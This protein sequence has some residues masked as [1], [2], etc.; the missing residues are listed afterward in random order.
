MPLSPGTR[1]GPYEV[2]SALGAGGMGEV[3][4]AV[5]TRLNRTVAIK[6][7]PGHLSRDPERRQRF[8]REARVISSLTHPNICTLYDVGQEGGVDFLVMEHL[9][10]E[11]LAD[12]LARERLGMDQVLKVGTDIVAAL[13]RAHRSGVIHRDLKPGNV[14]LTKTGAKLLDFGLA[15]IAEDPGDAAMT[16]LTGVRTAAQGEKPLTEKGTILG[17]FQYMAPE[18]LE[19]KE[20]DARTDLF[21]LGAVLYEMATGR[22]A[23]EGKSQASLIGAIMHAEPP[24]ISSLEPMN[25]PALDRLIKACLAKD[26]EE[27]I[28]TAHDVLLQ[29]RWI[30]EGGSQAGVPAPVAHRRRT[31]ERTAWSAAAVLAVACAAL[32]ATLFLRPA[33]P[34]STIRFRIAAPPGATSI[35]GPKI[36][37][38]GKSLAFSAVDSTGRAMLWLQPLSSLT[39]APVAG[40]EGALRPWWSADGRYLGY[41]AQGKL[42][43]VAVSGGPP[44]TICDAGG[45]ADG[46]WGAGDTIL[47]DG[48]PSDPIRRVPAGGG[49]AAAA[50]TSD[51]S[52]V[53]WP[54]FLPDGRH[55][56]YLVMGKDSRL[57]VGSLDGKPGVPLGITR[58]SRAEYSPAGYLLFV[59]DRSLLAQPFDAAKRQLRGEPVPIAE[60]VWSASNGAAQ[61]SVAAGG[62]LLYRSGGFYKAEALWL[63]R[64]GQE[65]E[66]VAAASSYANP[67]IAPDGK[68]VVLR[69]ADQESGSRDLWTIDPARGTKTRLTF[70]VPVIT[71]CVWSPDGKT[72]YYSAQDQGKA[73]NIFR[74]AASG[75]GASE[76]VSTSAEEQHIAD[77]SRDGKYLALMT[78]SRTNSFDVAVLSLDDGKLTPVVAT[79]ATEVLPRF[80]PDGRWI[81]YVSDESGRSEVYV[82]SFRGP[83]GKWQVSNQGGDE[84][85]WRADGKEIYY[86]GADKRLTAV[87][88]SAGDTFAAGVPKPLFSVNLSEGGWWQY[89]PSADGTRFLVLRPESAEAVAPITIVLNWAAELRGS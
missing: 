5:D 79:P 68:R 42:R 21:A 3:Y 53:G 11:S 1:L 7:L 13:D 4:R 16:A 66:R 55:F 40:T 62:T 82:Q 34:S 54:S 2:V 22:R 17:T 31:R 75:A 48:G 14:M 24:S 70:N 12:R 81:A 29:L 89:Q 43:K 45:G 35:D 63:N 78:T 51:S 60:D 26:P 36:S 87:E 8:E 38:D 25:P 18:Q 19:G 72:I 6:I 73:V 69:D 23:F 80:S 33:P 46:T 61:F 58:A 10:G 76:R 85:T 52:T 88:I 9:E 15:K 47:F 86:V 77:V 57:M 50:V 28:Q 39:A 37:P 27:R 67:S 71:S 49:V 32:S 56:L 84:P 59:R 44:Q 30:A 83:E 41:I 74:K 20:A 65:L 64:S